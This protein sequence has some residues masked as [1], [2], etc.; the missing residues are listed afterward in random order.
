[1]RDIAAEAALRHQ[2]TVDG[3]KEKTRR[4]AVSWPR[5]EAMAE[6][7]GAGFSHRQIARFFG[8][9]NHTSSVRACRAVAARYQQAID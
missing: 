4:R 6:M 9:D 1:M 2:M 8:F 5:Q 3:L 7:K